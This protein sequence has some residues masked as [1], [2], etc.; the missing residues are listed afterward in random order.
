MSQ[1]PKDTIRKRLGDFREKMA[2][3]AFDAVIV[4]STD[5]Y[6]NEY[7]PL[8][9][10]D[11]YYLSGFSGSTGDLLISDREAYLFVDGR[12]HTQAEKECDGEL[13]SVV[14]VALNDTVFSRLCE[15]LIELAREHS[16]GFKVSVDGRKISYDQYLSL[17]D[18]LTDNDA[19]LSDWDIEELSPGIHG[20][21]K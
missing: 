7:I 18:Y 5:E 3:L 1:I 19:L 10:N 4:R 9:E 2:E 6:L 12:Y 17:E 14:K 13:I 21:E 15:T 8:E 16:D 20:S 11:R